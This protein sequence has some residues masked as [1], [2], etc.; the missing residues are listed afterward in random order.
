M[1]ED[2]MDL[3]TLKNTPSWEWPKDAGNVL[4][5]ILR[6]DRAGES[7]R[8]IAA[9]LAGDPAVI[10]DDLAEALLAIA[11][12]RKEPD[13]LRSK[14]AISLGPIL[15]Y[16]DMDGF[17]DPNCVP[18]SDGVF[19]R[20]QDSLRDL[21]QEP[22]VSKELRRRIL[23]VSVRAPQDWHRDAILAA[24]SSGDESWKLTAVFCMRF[25]EGFDEQIVESLESEDEDTHYEAV[26]AA[27]NWEVDA[28][29]PHVVG[30]VTAP[31]TDKYLLLAAI[32]AV[33]GIRPLEAEDILS[34]LTD[35]E[36]EDIADA[37]Y[38]ALAMAGALLDDE[39]DE[40]DEDDDDRLLH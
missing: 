38:E 8:L 36:D 12:S 5:E 2:K 35:S 16:C 14:A 3:K 10:N 20:I 33:A 37:A 4:L 26:C 19:R 9:E 39:D 13:S 6:D 1:G 27:G 25:V 11:C 29:W 40:D 15:E 32:D 17:E 21:Y 22:D 24:Y 28:A 31:R 30:L 7:D 23:D 18:I 34:D